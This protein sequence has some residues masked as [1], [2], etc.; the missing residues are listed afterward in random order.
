MTTGHVDIMIL[1]AK[2][3]N[4]INWS[5]DNI[6]FYDNFTHFNSGYQKVF[7]IEKIK[8]CI[9]HM[10]N[11]RTMIALVIDELLYRHN[12]IEIQGKF[13]TITFDK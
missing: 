10:P 13:H 9:M 2:P 3:V 7:Y 5:Q 6:R 4:N 1:T 11:A 12:I 8:V